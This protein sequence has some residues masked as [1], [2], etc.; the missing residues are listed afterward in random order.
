[1]NT[2]LRIALRIA[3]GL[4][5]TFVAASCAFAWYFTAPRHARIDR[6]AADLPP[7]AEA[8]RF[9]AEDSV[10]LRGWYV[11]PR[12]AGG[13]VVILLHGYTGNR[14]HMLGR[15]RMLREAGIGALLYDARG[16][17]ESDG[18]KISMGYYE[19]SD[20]VGAARYLTGRGVRDIACIG[21]SQGG[22]TIA[23]A[24]GRLPGLRCA[25]LE[26][27]YDDMDHAIDHRFRHYIG[28]PGWLGAALMM[29]V[30]EWRLGCPTARIA[31]VESIGRLGCPVMI[32]SGW[33]DTRAPSDG[34]RRLFAAARAPKRLWLIPGADHEDL[35]DFAPG[36]YRE[37]VLGFLRRYLSTSPAAAPIAPTRNPPPAPAAPSGSRRPASPPA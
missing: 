10:T 3:V 27:T 24:A 13:P 28:V 21:V 36:P 26:S 14:T 18:D 9:A 6:A 30:A 20:L 32:I 33:D 17:G 31:P 19:A 8:I 12:E 4:A 37:R 1:M 34:A 2:K 23:F 22:A 29:P 15:M 35:L 7:E 25:I 11:P 5:A 16:C